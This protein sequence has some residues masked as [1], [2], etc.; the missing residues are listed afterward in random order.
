MKIFDTFCFFNE[1]E[2]LKLRCEELKPLNPIHVLVE[3]STTHSGDQKP[4]YFDEKKHL[5]SDYNIRHIKVHDLPNNGNNWDAENDQRDASLRGLFDCE[6]DDIIL[7]NDADEI[8]RWQAVQFYEP[9]MGTISLQ[10][11]K[12]SVYLNLLEGIQ[13]WGVAKVTTWGRLKDSTPN[14]IRNGGTDFTLYFGGWH[15]SFMGGIEKMKEKLFAYAH[16]ETVTSELLGSLEY[17]YETGQSL[18]GKDFWRFVE[19]DNTFPQYLYENQQEFSHLI[20]K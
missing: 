17:K 13:N 7:V 9:R 6:D 12:Y 5:F 11:D 20:K 10:Q 16:A 19:I 3:A 1:F 4:F 8:P 15:M 2:I 18:W 14:K